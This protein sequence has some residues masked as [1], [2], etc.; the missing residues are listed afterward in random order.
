ML[1][2]IVA[3]RFQ[4]RNREGVVHEQDDNVEHSQIMTVRARR[5]G[6]V[7]SLLSCSCEHDNCSLEQL[8]CF[9]GFCRFFSLGSGTEDLARDPK[10]HQSVLTNRFRDL[11][12]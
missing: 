6:E 1:A 8:K 3:P 9:L 12:I 11:P 2:P 4:A 10:F 5:F 7:R